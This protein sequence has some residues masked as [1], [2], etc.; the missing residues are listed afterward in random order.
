MFNKNKIKLFFIFLLLQAGFVFS[1]TATFTYAAGATYYNFDAAEGENGDQTGGIM[2]VGSSMSNLIYSV[3]ANFNGGGWFNINGTG[4]VGDPDDGTLYGNG[5]FRPIYVGSE[6]QCQIQFSHAELTETPGWPGE[7]EGITFK[8]RIKDQNG[9]SFPNSPG[10]RN[11]DLVKPTLSSVSIVSDNSDDEWATTNDEIKVTLTA[12]NE[13][14][15]SE[16]EWTATIQGLAATIAATG[17]AKVWEVTAS[18]TSHPE[19]TAVFNILYYDEYENRAVAS[20]TGSTDGTTVIIDKTAPIVSATILS[21]DNEDNAT[22]LATTGDDVTLTITAEDADGAPELIQVPTVTITGETPDTKNPNV[23]ASSYTAMRTMEAGDAQGTV[24][25]VISAIKDRAGNTADNVTTTSDGN[26]VTFDSVVPTLSVVSIASDNSISDDQAKVGDF[27]TVSFTATGNESLQTPVVT[28]DGEAATEAQNGNDYTWTATKEMDAEDNEQDVVFNISFKDLAANLGTAVTAVLDASSVE[29]DGTD[30]SINSTTLETTND[31]DDELATADDVIIINITSA[32][33]LYSIKDAAIA[34]QSVSNQTTVATNITSWTVNHTVTG[35]E[36]DGYASYTYTAVDLA[37]NTT[38]VTSASSDIRID[39]T[40]PELNT[41]E[42]YSDNDD[43]T[44]AKIGDIVTV[45]IVANEQLRAASP[46]VISIQANNATIIAA[47]DGITYTGTYQMR[48][49]D[50]EGDVTFTIAFENTLGVAGT[51]IIDDGTGSNTTNNSAVVFDR[52]AP[53]LSAVTIATDNDRPAY[54]KEGSIITLTFT[55]DN[56]EN[57]LADPTVT[58]LTET[59]AVAGNGASWTATYTA[60]ETDTEGTVPFTIDFF[61]YSG[62][63]GTRVTAIMDGDDVIFDMSKPTLATASITSSNDN[64]PTGTLAKV[65]DVITVTITATNDEGLREPEITIAGNDAIIAGNEGQPTFTATYQMQSSDAT[66]DAIA[67]TVDFLDLAGN[68]GDQQIDLIN[69]SD[70]GVSFDKQAP[71]FTD[72]SIASDNDVIDGDDNTDDDGT[73]AKSGDEITVTF[74]SD[75]ILHADNPT[76]KIADNGAIVTRDGT[77]FTAVYEMSDATDAAY[78]GLAIPIEIS[79]YKDLSGNPGDDVIA[80]LDGSEVIFDITAPTLGTVT[81]ESSNNNFAHWAKQEDVIT[82]TIISDEDLETTPAVSL[83]GSAE[84]DTPVPGVDAKNWSFTKPVA[85][86]SPQGT[87]AFSVTFED[88]VGN[89]GTV[90]TSVTAG[91]N[92]IVDRGDPTINIADIY[93]DLEASPHLSTPQDGSSVISLDVT[94]SE[95]IL[96]PTISIADQTAA[97][98]NLSDGDAKTW[99]GTYT[100][101]EAADN[102]EIGFVITFTDSA[103]NEGDDRETINND[104]DG[105]YVNFD[106]T[107]PTF[108][109]VTISSDNAGNNQYARDGSLITLSFQ[110][111]EDLASTSVTINNVV[112]VASLSGDTYTAIRE[113]TEDT[114]DND[115]A[116]YEVP[117]SIFGTD[118]NGYNSHEE[119]EALRETSDETSITLDHTDPAV[120]TLI[121]TSNNDDPTLAKVGDVLTLELVATEFLQQPTFSI[122]GETDIA[123]LAG[124]TNASWSGTYEMDDDDTE[125]D[126]AI[127]VDFMDYAGNSVE[128]E[129]ATSDGSAIRFDRTV[130]TLDVVTIVSDNI[131]SNQEA[132]TGDILTL[133]IEASE[134]LKTAPMFTIGIG[135]A[136]AATQG[137]DASEWSGTYMMQAG[138]A[139]GAVEFSIT[140][141]DLAANPGVAVTATSDEI[142]VNFDKTATNISEVVVDLVD[143]SDSGNC[144]ADCETDNLTND[145]TPEFQIT[146]L[147]PGV[148]DDAKDAVGDSIFIY[149]DGVRT[150]LKDGTKGGVAISSDLTLVLDTLASQELA[151]EIKVRSQD[152]AGNL[153]EFSTSIDIRIDTQVPATPGTPNLQ[154]LTDSGFFNDDNITNVQLPSFRIY[155]GTTDNDSIRIYYNVGDDDVLAGGFRDTNDALFGIY[156]LENALSGNT[157]TFTAIA[158][159]SAGMFL[160]KVMGLM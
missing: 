43:I 65:G 144:G 20:V 2:L 53:T 3:Q 9:N 13:N 105:L 118:L 89:S 148:A 127:Q 130:P 8:L 92:V 32:E 111:S 73:R 116:G 158:E 50:T 108:N 114:D 37:G 87:V 86:G 155:D 147:R 156:T 123:E 64:A 134:D 75:D 42:I 67:F 136:F 21:D 51:T 34:G 112:T 160:L 59:A 100:M 68:A 95:N 104:S 154:E 35:D 94:A 96:E 61:D 39:N 71:F 30:P 82:L 70:D 31:Y 27:V 76:V 141:E 106:K 117:F 128:T 33:P 81:I 52:T 24:A 40:P 10:D 22:T 41:I 97:V 93:S 157:Y 19:G 45:K 77:T 16:D 80:T 11:F 57:L 159:D 107:Q 58:I 98:S 29:F 146:N 129:T 132:T 1:Q 125:G 46:P 54:A 56:A 17:N 55:A 99:Q 6:Y 47:G 69:D 103:G 150:D 138:D 91:K 25:F 36:D 49:I 60:L 84:G 124:G 48:N 15:G 113:I 72:V 131:I 44:Q 62:N 90:V 110:S 140:F 12:Y 151:Y 139:E 135:A 101:T 74:I 66:A 145:I 85:G 28:I 78:D 63:A 83:L 126:Q 88:V 121:L 79:S 5:D 152:Q 133:S 137:D 38:T 122:A 14:L 102:G 142:S 7:V 119:G 26:N 120:T 4:S 153:S 115:G 149:V 18:V 109:N 143:G 23:A